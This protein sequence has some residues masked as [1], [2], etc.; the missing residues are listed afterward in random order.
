M[1]LDLIAGL[2][3]ETYERFAQSFDDAYGAADL[4]QL[5]FLKL[6]YG[7][8]LREN[9]MDY[10]YRC[11]PHP[12]Y[13]VLQSKWMSYEDLQRLSHVAEVLERYLE[14]ERFAHAL[15]YVMPL[16]KSPFVFWEGLSKLPVG[17]YLVVYGEEYDSR[18]CNP[19]PMEYA[20]TGYECMF[21]LLVTE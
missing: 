3:Y 13:T 5:G 1:H 7:T 14:S 6:L 16:V 11:L 12:P 15:W 8:P 21:R 2:P 9:A 17:D 20:I 4:L 10:G 19:E 18:G